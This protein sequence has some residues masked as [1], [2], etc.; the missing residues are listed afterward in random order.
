MAPRLIVAFR[1]DDLAALLNFLNV[2]MPMAGPKLIRERE[3]SLCDAFVVMETFDHLADRLT[4]HL[5]N[6]EW[7]VES[8]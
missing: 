2:T 5:G 6:E 3:V 1:P 7:L 4:E 8:K